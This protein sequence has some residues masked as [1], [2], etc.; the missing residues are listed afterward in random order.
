MS[1]MWVRLNEKQTSLQTVTVFLHFA[2]RNSVQVTEEHSVN[3][4][5]GQ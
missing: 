5:K 4:T 2:P 3:K 1:C